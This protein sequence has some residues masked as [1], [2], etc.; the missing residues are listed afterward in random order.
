MSNDLTKF[1]PNSFD[2]L[3][4]LCKML[5]GTQLVP[6][7]LH[8]KTEDIL[9]IVMMGADLRSQSGAMGCW[10]LFKDIPAL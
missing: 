9:A 5:A 3:L 1:N 8:G 6:R 2:E 7:A 10:Q 4:T